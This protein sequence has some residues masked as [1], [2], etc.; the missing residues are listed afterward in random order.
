ML[1]ITLQK[2]PFSKFCELTIHDKKCRGLTN[3]QS[4]CFLILKFY[5]A[6]TNRR[7]FYYY[8]QASFHLDSIV[9]CLQVAPSLFFIIF[10]FFVK[11]SLKEAF[12]ISSHEN[13]LK[14][15]FSL[16]TLCSLLMRTFAIN[17]G[18]KTKRFNKKKEK[19][20]K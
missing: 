12:S 18:K 3:E 4:K 11:K 15:Y 13:K 10:V 7:L 6:T 20:Y 8:F 2:R 14:N 9:S 17:I 1:A 5:N 16:L 19:L